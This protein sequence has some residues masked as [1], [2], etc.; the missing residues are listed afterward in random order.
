[1]AYVEVLEWA[2]ALKS[3]GPTFDTRSN[4]SHVGPELLIYIHEVSRDIHDS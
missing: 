3:L 1:M 4:A 2:L